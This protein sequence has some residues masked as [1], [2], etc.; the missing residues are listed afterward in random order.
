MDKT[1]IDL[2]PVRLR[3]LVPLWNMHVQQPI[4]A[5]Y[6]SLRYVDFLRKEMN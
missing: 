4:H 6:I 3:F 1:T 5:I 2:V